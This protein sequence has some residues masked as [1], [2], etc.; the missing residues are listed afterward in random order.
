MNPHTGPFKAVLFDLDGTLL[1]T[2]EDLGASVNRVLQRAGFPVHPIDSYRYFVGEGASMLV[3]RSLPP[4]HRQPAEVK[5]FLA[6]YRAEYERS[7]AQ[8]TKPYEGIPELLDELVNRGLRL[9]IL[10]NKPHGMTLKC[11]EH[12][13]AR[14][15]FA[16]VL[17]QRDQVARKPD[18]SGAHE[19][20]GIMQVA[21][22]EV[23]YVGDTATDMQTARAA[24]MFALG[25]TWGFRTEKELQENGAHAIAHHP[26]EIPPLIS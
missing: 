9:G 13:L 2:L 16:V 1:D 15:H 7:W 23:L 21:P 18:P 10:S 5:H 22:G 12:Y 4:A 17:G 8:T 26:R 19:A 11:V 20:A 14:W 24:G 3:E 25:C 6:E